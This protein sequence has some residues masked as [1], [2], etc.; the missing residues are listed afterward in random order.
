MPGATRHQDALKTGEAEYRLRPLLFW[1]RHF[2][3]FEEHLV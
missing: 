2:G 3:E 1:Q